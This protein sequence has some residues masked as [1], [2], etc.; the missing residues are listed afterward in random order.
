M[1]AFNVFP[2]G[3]LSASTASPVKL[4]FI[5]TGFIYAIC[6]DCFNID[7]DHA[8]NHIATIAG[9]WELSSEKQDGTRFDDSDWEKEF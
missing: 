3:Y 9:R 5:A 2:S 1:L 8:V 7:F 4:D 6:R